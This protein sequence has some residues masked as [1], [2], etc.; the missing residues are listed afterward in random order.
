MISAAATTQVA[1][2]GLWGPTFALGVLT[3]GVALFTLAVNQIRT[4]KDRQR[5]LAADA[6]AALTEYREYP[7]IVRRRNGDGSDRQTITAELSSVQA[8]L[9]Q[10]IARL[11]VEAPRVGRAYAQLAADTRRVAGAEISRAWDLEPIPPDA[12]LHVRDVD[13]SELVA[14]DDTFLREVGDH[15]AVLPAWTRRASRAAWRWVRH[16]HLRRSAATPTA[17]HVARA[18]VRQ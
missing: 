13:L 2:T 3:A 17:P 18:E 8:R 1:S 11:R 12:P 16:R 9:N 15:L 6:F 14:S 10:F 4:R 7:F 5:E